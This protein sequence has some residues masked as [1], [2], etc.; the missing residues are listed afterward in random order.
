METPV[1]RVLPEVANIDR[2]IP[3]YMFSHNNIS[4]LLFLMASVPIYYCMYFNFGHLNILN[5]QPAEPFQKKS[6]ETDTF[7]SKS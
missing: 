7:I 1:T 2:N 5:V 6:L 3:S 4:Y